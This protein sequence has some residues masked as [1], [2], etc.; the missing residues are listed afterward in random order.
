MATLDV[1]NNDAFSTTS[2]TAA[3]EKVPHQPMMLSSMGIFEPVPVRTTTVMIEK[4]EGA[5][6]LIKTDARGNPPKQRTSELRSAF[7]VSTV[8]IAKADT[9]FA[10]ELQ[11]IRAFGSESEFMQVQAEVARRFS[12]PTGIVRDIELTWENM[13]L[14]A[15][16]GIVTDADGAELHNWFTLTGESQ[17][18][19]IDFDL[20]NASPASGAVRKLCAQVIRQMQRA[21]AGAWTTGTRVAALC[22]DTFWDQLIAHSEVRTTYLNYQAASELRGPTAWEQLQYGGITFINYRGTDDNSTVAIPVTKAKF[23]PVGAPGVFQVAWAPGESFEWVNTPGRDM[24]AF[25]VPD[26]DR[27]MKVDV[28]AYSY[29]LFYCT[30]PGMLQRAKNT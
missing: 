17:A 4:R 24:Y 25:T 9:I 16:Q 8:R 11:N 18:T 1:F 23:F 29:P 7:N 5:L 13:R 2:L 28:E 22:G 15:V 27:N 20:D 14:G 30:R 6:S 26:R 21:S 12:G 19:E 10:S 3:I